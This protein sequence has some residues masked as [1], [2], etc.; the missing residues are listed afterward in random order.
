MLLDAKKLTDTFAKELDNLIKQK[1]GMV[2]V[3]GDD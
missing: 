1:M 2:E 3:S